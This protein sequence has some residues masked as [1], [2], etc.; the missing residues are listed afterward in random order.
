VHVHHANQLGV[1]VKYAF[2]LR[3]RCLHRRDGAICSQLF[4]GYVIYVFI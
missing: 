3:I 1:C 4:L 2:P